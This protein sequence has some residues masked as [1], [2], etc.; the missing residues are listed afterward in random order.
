MN[1]ED[2]RQA[3]KGVI[4]NL[5]GTLSFARF[6]LQDSPSILER[7]LL[8]SSFAATSTVVY[9]ARVHELYLIFRYF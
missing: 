9:W 7:Y 3:Y 1:Q 4:T 8:P 2:A 5:C 6:Q